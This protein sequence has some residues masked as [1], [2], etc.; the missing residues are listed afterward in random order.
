M[1]VDLLVLAAEGLE[2]PGNTRNVDSG[3]VAD[4]AEAVGQA[5]ATLEEKSPVVPAV[6]ADRRV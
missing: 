1:A 6:L 2:S 4:S 3:E 5:A